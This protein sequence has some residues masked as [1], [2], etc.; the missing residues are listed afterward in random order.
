MRRGLAAFVGGPTS[1]RGFWLL[2]QAYGLL[3][4]RGRAFHRGLCG[5]AAFVVGGRL[6]AGVAGF[7]PAVAAGARP[8]PGRV[9]GGCF[10]GRPGL[11]PRLLA[12]G[13][14]PTACYRREGAPPTRDCAGWLLLWEARPRGEAFR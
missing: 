1:G 8:R 4:P 14:G 6:V 11:G 10:C 9:R 12:F 2:R 3:S 5:L 13:A 7:R